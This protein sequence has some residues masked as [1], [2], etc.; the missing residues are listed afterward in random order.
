ML[1]W[2]LNRIAN[3]VCAFLPPAI[4]SK[5]PL[6]HLSTNKQEKQVD[7]HDT[8]ITTCTAVSQV[9][10]NACGNTIFSCPNLKPLFRSLFW[11]AGKKN[12]KK[13]LGLARYAWSTERTLLPASSHYTY[14][15]PI[16]WWKLTHTDADCRAVRLSERERET[17]ET[18]CY[19]IR[20]KH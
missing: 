5:S 4:L 8:R 2:A 15:A 20:L 12:K 18:S 1:L 13:L 3:W 14:E 16:S 10:Q 6:T 9:H 11:Q 7:N 19:L 17:L